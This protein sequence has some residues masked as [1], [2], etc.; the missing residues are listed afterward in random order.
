MSLPDKAPAEGALSVDE[1]S[2]LVRRLGFRPSKPAS[3]EEVEAAW[4]ASELEP[5]PEA[6]D[7]LVR[8]AEATIADERERGRQLD[9][10]AGQFVG[11]S[12]VII[13]LEAALA[14]TVFSADLG[15]IGAVIAVVSYLVAIGAALV[16]ATLAVGGVLMPQKYRG[17]GRE[18]IREFRF[19][20][21][22]STPKL[23]VDRRMLGA[24]DVILHQD[25]P[26][27]DFKARVTKR[28]AAALLVGFIGLAVQGLTLGIHA[29]SA[30]KSE[31]K[32]PKTSSGQSASPKPFTTEDVSKSQKDGDKK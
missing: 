6:V 20:D 3:E 14:K 32:P 12:G 31:S 19:P 2:W 24:A 4:A 25:R 22:Q 17:F 29:M 13:S 11:F 27:N 18:Q 16:A 21:S 23:E 26:V 15:T 28:V 10:K 30:D 8:I 9:A 1:G 5:D 7:E